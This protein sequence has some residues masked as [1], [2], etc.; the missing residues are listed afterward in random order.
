[1]LARQLVGELALGRRRVGQF[2]DRQSGQH[3]ARMLLEDILSGGVLVALLDQQPILLVLWVGAAAAASAHERERAVELE[4][5][6]V[7]IDFSLADR[8]GGVARRIDDFVNA[9]IPHDDRACAIVARRNHALEVAIL[10]RMVL[11][12]DREMLVGGIHR[13]AFRNRPRA[14]DIFHLESKIVVEASRGVLL[15]DESAAGGGGGGWDLAPEG[16]G[17]ARRASFAPV[18]GQRHCPLPRREVNSYHM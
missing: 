18:L 8:V 13:G 2:L 1:M 15:Y 10:Q 4:A 5:V 9:A 3:G 14:Q 11:D 6:Q 7:D 17:S 16:F 12:G